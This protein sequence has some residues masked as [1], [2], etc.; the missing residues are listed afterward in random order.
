MPYIELKNIC[1]HICRDVNLEINDSELMV[2]LGH[3]GAGKTTLLNVIAGLTEY[4]GSVIANGVPL[5]KVAASKRKIGYLF[6]ELVLFPHLDVASNIAYSL[7]AQKVPKEKIMHRVDRLLKMLRITH[8]SSR[9]PKNLSGGEKQ[10]VALGRALACAPKV[11]LLD[12]PM[13]S[14]DGQTAKHLRAELKQIQKELGITTIY[15]T[16]DLAEAEEMADRIAVIHNGCIEQVAPPNEVF[17]YPRS[18]AVSDFIGAPNILDC[19]SYREL[20]QGVI[21]VKCCGLPIIVAHEG[22]AVQRIALF[23]RDI[24]VSDTCPPGAGVNRFKGT[25]VDIRYIDDSVRLDVK[26]GERKL[27]TEVSQHI[28]NEME[29][30]VGKEA[31]LILK[32]R[33]IRTYEGRN[34]HNKKG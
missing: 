34:N 3:S 16:H 27:V 17:F 1:R 20:E 22:N 6:Q 30:A 13:S 4:E 9:Y 5:D 21:E 24:Y 15:V 19:D 23:P 33:R 18:E 7:K 29:L 32:L 25:V 28:F 12:E 8:L 11:L 26:V 14:L 10:R 31:Y 2:L